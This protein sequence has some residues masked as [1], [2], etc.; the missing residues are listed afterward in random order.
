MGS[1]NEF[2]HYPYL[3]SLNLD[4]FMIGKP[5][6]LNLDHEPLIKNDLIISQETEM[7]SSAELFTLRNIGEDFLQNPAP[8]M[9]KID[10]EYMNWQQ[11][12]MVDSMQLVHHQTVVESNFQGFDQNKVMDLGNLDKMSV[13]TTQVVENSEDSHI[14][15]EKIHGSSDELMAKSVERRQKRMIKN[16]ES[17][18]RSRARKQAYI[19]QLQSNVLQL[20]TSNNLLRKRKV[21]ITH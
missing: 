5:M 17:A 16:R 20:Q 7:S 19:D 6:N 9:T 3:V 10:Q 21:L 1:P 2:D 12:E 11:Q 14:E 8:L 13:T 18:A 15:T 4:E